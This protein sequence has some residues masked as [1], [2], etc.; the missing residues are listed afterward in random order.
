MTSG[1]ELRERRDQR[2][3]PRPCIAGA[4]DPVRR[5]ATSLIVALVQALGVFVPRGISGGSRPR[6]RG[7]GMG[8]ATR[9]TTNAM[10]LNDGMACSTGIIT[11]AFPTGRLRTASPRHPRPRAGYQN[12]EDVYR[13]YELS[14]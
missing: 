3:G 11:H 9:H 4:G 12:R 1:I 13:Y 2:D 5:G 7:G 8:S 6:L 14:D 10:V